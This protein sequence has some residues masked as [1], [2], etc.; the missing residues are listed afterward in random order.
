MCVHRSHHFFLLCHN[1][2]STWLLHPASSVYILY[3]WENNRGATEAPQ[4]MQVT[5]TLLTLTSAHLI[6]SRNFSSLLGTVSVFTVKDQIK[7]KIIL[8]IKTFTRNKHVFTNSYIMVLVLCVYMPDFWNLQNRC[9]SQGWC[10]IVKLHLHFQTGCLHF[11][12]FLPPPNLN[13]A[14]AIN[15]MRGP[16]QVRKTACG[17]NA[18]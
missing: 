8:L 10:Q 3:G 1:L 18:L 15:E 14:N 2:H 12:Q 16:R 13:R 4:S 5:F 7:T 11:L 17:F 9:W 6:S